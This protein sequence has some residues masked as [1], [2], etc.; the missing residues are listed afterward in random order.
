MATYKIQPI[1]P[2]QAAAKALLKKKQPVG[3]LNPKKPVVEQ[4]KGRYKLY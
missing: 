3:G 1:K 2:I 4:P